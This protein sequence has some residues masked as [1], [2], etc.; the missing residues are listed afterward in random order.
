MVPSSWESTA[1]VTASTQVTSRIGASS[2]AITSGTSPRRT[3]ASELSR[4]I[5]HAEQLRSV[6][7]L[8]P[9]QQPGAVPRDVE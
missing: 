9:E 6:R 3:G 1:T 7:S 5:P 4:T 8:Q 2:I